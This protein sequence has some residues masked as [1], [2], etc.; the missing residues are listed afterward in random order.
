MLFNCEIN[1]EKT[2]KKQ[3]VTSNFQFHM[4]KHF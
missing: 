4:G 3:R 2:E 1:C